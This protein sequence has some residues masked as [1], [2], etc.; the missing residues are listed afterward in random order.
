[1]K[2]E[3]LIDLKSKRVIRQH[4]YLQLASSLGPSVQHS[5]LTDV[6]EDLVQCPLEVRHPGLQLVDL[7][8][9]NT[10]WHIDQV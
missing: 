6:G 5:T 10:W 7:F 3:V 2:L 8:L 1:M 4:R 9:M